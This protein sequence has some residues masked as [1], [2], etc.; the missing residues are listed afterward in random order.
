M[1]PGLMRQPGPERKLLGPPEH[2]PAPTP[3]RRFP[4]SRAP[5]KPA[6]LTAHVP[7]R[8]GLC[9]GHLFI[10]SVPVHEAVQR[11]LVER[12]DADLSR[13]TADRGPPGLD[14]LLRSHP[15][16]DGPA[17]ADSFGDFVC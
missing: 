2:L 7:G 6:V 3:E 5:S 1:S 8:V 10:T 12:Q 16:P 17:P 15:G 4:A 14:S 11:S 9:L 13:V